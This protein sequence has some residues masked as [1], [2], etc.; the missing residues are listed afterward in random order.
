MRPIRSLHDFKCAVDS[1]SNNHTVAMIARS[2]DEPSQNCLRFWNE[3]AERVDAAEILWVDALQVP[4]VALEFKIIGWPTFLFFSNGQ[5]DTTK[6]VVGAHKSQLQAGLMA[7]ATNA[8]SERCR[9][10]A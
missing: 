4:D 2:D 6:R 3:L 1:E 10:C 9:Q 8:Q 5:E 7:V